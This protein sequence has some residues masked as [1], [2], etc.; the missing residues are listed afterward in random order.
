MKTPS[1]ILVKAALTLPVTCK[2]ALMAAAE[3]EPGWVAVSNQHAENG[4]FI[5]PQAEPNL[6]DL[7]AARVF[8][9]SSEVAW[10]RAAFPH[11][12]WFIGSNTVSAGIHLPLFEALTAPECALKAWGIEVPK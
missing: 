1:K 11:G 3:G 7:E 6:E 9:P 5:Y 12:V 4:Y 8:L 10:M 2:R